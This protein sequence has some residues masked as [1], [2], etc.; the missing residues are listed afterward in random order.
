MSWLCLLAVIPTQAADP[1][2]PLQAIPENVDLVLAV[3]QP[4]RLVNT[5]KGLDLFQQLYK[6]EL[7]QDFYDTGPARRLAQVLYYFERE[8]G[9]NREEMIERLAGRGAV[10]AVKLAPPSFALLVVQGKDEAMLRKFQAAGLRLLE[11]ELAR[12][13]IQNVIKKATHRSIEAVHVGKDFCAAMVGKTLLASNSRQ[14]LQAGI[15][16][17]LDSKR[18]AADKAD[19]VTARRLLPP[20]PLAWAYL[21]LEL[22]RRAPQLQSAF[23]IPNDNPALPLFLGGYLDVV[24][25]APFVTAGLYHRPDGLLAT[26]RLP[27]GRQGSAAETAAHVP[28]P[29]QP[30]SRPLLQ[31]KN[32][33][34]S[35]SY[36]FDIPK[37]W[38]QRD[39]LLNPQQLEF[40][41]AIEK[42]SGN[43]KAGPAI[44]QVLNQIGAY[45]RFVVAAPE[46]L[47]YSVEPAQRLPA[48]AFVLELR[49]PKSFRQMVDLQLRTAAL[50][51][52][53]QLRLQLKEEKIGQHLLVGY[54][55]DEKAKLD[56][57]VNNLRFNFSPC[58]AVIGNQF[59]ICSTLELGRELAGILD[60]EANGDGQATARPANAASGRTMLAAAGSAVFLQGVEEQLA[61]QAMLQRALTPEVAGRQVRELLDRLRGAGTLHLEATYGDQEFRYDVELRLAK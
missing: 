1:P 9:A 11:S 18:S 8:L 45:Q 54:R 57:D 47:S 59:L 27:R 39:K 42:Q 32:T 3:D 60:R 51:L 56:A 21:N 13:E 30:G 34:F 22:V 19:L 52:T 7:I 61:L 14:G 37:L 24:R 50:F 58:F 16:Q 6:L 35:T 10:L 15:D 29:G 28:P 5:I 48:A 2:Q 44:S 41:N 55:F 20:D 38:E 43:Q 25:R 49:D 36:F 40:L 33:L 23:A 53:T 46:G 17:L 4:S 31:P 12:L 26:L